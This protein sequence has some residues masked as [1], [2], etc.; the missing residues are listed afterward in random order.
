MS[1]TKTNNK[2]ELFGISYKYALKT[3]FTPSE[4][5]MFLRGVNYVLKH[6]S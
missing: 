5:E 2:N 6:L 1:I 3:K 4:R